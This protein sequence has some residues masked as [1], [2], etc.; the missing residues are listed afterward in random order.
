MG[1]K[2]PQKPKQIH[3][4]STKTTPKLSPTP[5]SKSNDFLRQSDDIRGAR[6][7]HFRPMLGVPGARAGFK[8]TYL[9]A[10]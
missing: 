5:I 2:D 1:K 10:L 8:N 7:P 4:Q 6:C 9:L 3:Q